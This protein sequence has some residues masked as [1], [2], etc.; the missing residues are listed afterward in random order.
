MKKLNLPLILGG[1]IVFFIIIIMIF[2]E[3]FTDVNPYGIEQIKAW[4]EEGGR[5]KLDAA[6]FPPSKDAILGTDELGRDTLSFII[7]GTKLTISLGLLVVIG[8]FLIALP[9]GIT[10]GFGNLVSRTIINQFNAIFSAIPALLISLIVLK[11]DFFIRLDREQSILAF[12]LILS[13]VGWSKLGLIIMERVGEILAEPFIKGEI[14]IGK[15][16]F[17]IALENVIPHLA[18]EIVV[19]FF[20]EI[21]RALTLIMQLGVFS[22]FVGNLRIIEDTEGGKII[23][24]DISFEPEWASMLGT[25]RNEIRRAPWTVFSPAFAFFISV[26]GFNLLGEG[27]RRHLQQ[28][29]SRF[30]PVLRKVLSLD[31]RILKPKFLRKKQNMKL[32]F[33]TV[34]IF[35]LTL[36]IIS[37]LIFSKVDKYEFACTDSTYIFNSE[38]QSRAIIGSNEAKELATKIAKEM[39]NTGLKPLYEEG[40]IKKYK[41]DDIYIPVSSSFEVII[42]EEKRGLV[43]G[44]DYSLLSFYDI[45][46]SGEI[47]DATGDDMFNIMDYNKFSEKFIVIDK[48]F[49][50]DDAIKYFAKSIFEKSTAKGIL[51]IARDDEILQNSLGKDIYKGAVVQITQGVGKFLTEKENI[52]ISICT[53]NKKLH[54]IGRNV[55]GILPGKDPKVGEEAI[56]IGLSYNYIDK[57]IGLKRLQFALELMKRLSGDQINRNRSIIFAFWDGTIKDEYDGIRDYVED[58]LYPVNKS[59]LYIDL[60]KLNSYNY[61]YLFYSSDQAP[62]TRYFAWS[63]GHQFEQNCNKEGIEIKEYYVKDYYQSKLQGSLVDNKMFIERGIATIIIRTS[64]MNNEGRFTLEDLGKLLVKTINE[65][66]Y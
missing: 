65:N 29:D 10:A 20:M 37:G 63:L 42:E 7:Y 15:S 53:H 26:L 5:F 51:C 60:S 44:K 31:F 2:P 9:L 8:R 28:R 45:D 32:R 24:K 13:F 50:S 23:Q 6:P 21:A 59:T 39:E 3:I 12:V 33:K 36:A 62:I 58:I 16:R 61:D 4:T 25:A 18:A 17:K 48:R 30:I 64:N 47:Y 57:E 55:L 66:N 49:Y 46:S 40:F 38:L 19:L 54:N 34:G 14:A 56:I 11:F 41:T 52:N 27:F 1:A 43:L 22:V 35:I